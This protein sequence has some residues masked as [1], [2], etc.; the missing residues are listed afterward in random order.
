MFW[1]SITVCVT[2]PADWNV[3]LLNYLDERIIICGTVTTTTP[4][5]IGQLLIAHFEVVGNRRIKN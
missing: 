4:Y 3:G 2:I 5:I 1:W